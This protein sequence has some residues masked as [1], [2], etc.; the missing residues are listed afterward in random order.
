MKEISMR[1]VKELLRLKFEKKLSY[2]QIAKSL[3]VGR[4]TVYRCLKKAKEANLEWPIS[5]KVTDKSLR[6]LLYPNDSSR[7]NYAEE[8]LPPNFAYIFKELKKKGVTLMQLWKEYNEVYPEGCGYSQF[9][10]KY[11]KWRACSDL[12]MPQD[13]VAGEELFVDYAGLTVPIYL[14]DGRILSAQIFVGVL[15]ASS[16]TYTEATATQGLE[17]WIAS[18][19]RMFEFFEGVP[20]ILVPDN[21]KSGVVKPD[22]YEPDLNPTYYEMARHYGAAILPA[23]V[24]RPKDKAKAENGVLNIER[25][26][27]AP[28]RNRKFFSIKELNV[29]IGVI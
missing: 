9:C 26:L 24:R 2:T 1:K 18:H 27:L 25:K 20:E 21:L 22:L 4:S 11:R 19:K 16:Y 10:S 6:N 12:W 28:L 7:D 13:H 23:R 17:D 15:G 29:P 8:V 3:G 14:K 5:D